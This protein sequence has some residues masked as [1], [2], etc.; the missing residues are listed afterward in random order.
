MQREKLLVDHVEG[1]RDFGGWLQPLGF[2][3][4]NAFGNRDGG[5]PPRSFSF[6]LRQDLVPHEQALALAGCK[7]AEDHAA[8]DL[9]CCVKQFMQ[10]R[11]LQQ[12]P[13]LVLPLNWACRVQHLVPSRVHHKRDLNAD[14]ARSYMRL[15]A[16]RELPPYNLL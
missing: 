5:E 4:Y 14:L 16:V 15:A 3:L 1:I 6:K 13:A 11:E 9:M 2:I 7:G 10:D 8:G 12:P